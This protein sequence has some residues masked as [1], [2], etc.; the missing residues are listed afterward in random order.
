MMCFRTT[1]GKK[2]GVLSKTS[3]NSDS[4]RFP[5][6]DAGCSTGAFASSRGKKVRNA[7]YRDRQR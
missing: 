4:E 3:G 5:D 6:D 1:A 2:N 7:L